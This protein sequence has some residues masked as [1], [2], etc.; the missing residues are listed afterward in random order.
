VSFK[1]K[2]AILVAMAVML[3]SWAVATCVI[4]VLKPVSSLSG[5][6]VGPDDVPVEAANIR[7]LASDGKTVF[8][9][10]SGKDGRFSLKNVKPSGQLVEIRAKGFLRYNYRLGSSADS[11]RLDKMRLSL[12]SECNCF[13]VGSMRVSQQ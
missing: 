4:E 1:A 12:S 7:V 2:V 6:V 5:S 10:K 9:T 13:K 8:D 3:N 11:I